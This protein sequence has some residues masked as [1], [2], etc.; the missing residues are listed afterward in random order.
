MSASSEPSSTK[1]RVRYYLD[2]EI[3]I[4]SSPEASLLK[5]HIARLT[6][7]L[8]KAYDLQEHMTL[9]ACGT[10]ALPLLPPQEA[11]R[12]HTDSYVRFLQQIANNGI[13]VVDEAGNYAL[14]ASVCFSETAWQYAQIYAGASVDAASS[15]SS[16]AADI[17]INWIGGQTHARRDCASGFS[18]VNDVVLAILTMLRTHERVMFVS[19]DACHPSGVEEAFYTTDRV[20]CVSLHRHG[21]GFFPG[22]G[23]AKDN[24][25]AAGVNHTLN[26]PVS[27]GLNDEQISSLFVPVVAAAAERFQP[28]CVV[29]CAG[30]GVLAGDRLGCLNVCR[31]R[32]ARR[33]PS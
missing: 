31:P 20:L 24:G 12:F 23:G 14:N 18:Y 9:C 10:P 15:L 17:A 32:T 2:P 25:A 3:G 8:V 28:S 7:E 29:Y 11:C 21:E 13:D 22:S 1:R 33:T 27:E 5:P 26:M 16:G 30:A 4:H 6:D 19:C